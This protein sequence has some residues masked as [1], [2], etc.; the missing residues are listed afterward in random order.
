MEVIHL[1]VPSA[2]PP[3]GLQQPEPFLSNIDVRYKIVNLS[4]WL[5]NLMH[6]VNYGVCGVIHFDAP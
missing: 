5:N 6:H 1:T 2:Q 3:M 4:H